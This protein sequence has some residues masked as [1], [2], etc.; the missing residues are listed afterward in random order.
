MFKGRKY[1]YFLVSLQFILIGLLALNSNIRSN[2]LYLL[3]FI[4]GVFVG[5]W[6]I[7]VM[8]KSKLRITPDVADSAILIKAGP[9][10]F[11]RHPMYLSVLTAC[12]SFVLSNINFLTI[13]FFVFLFLDLFLKMNYEEKLLQK[14]FSNYSEYMTKTKRLIPYLY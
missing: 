12:L 9:Y 8:Q 7:L 2:I 14:A 5:G 10:K 11:I 1:S 4:L 13:L 3:I 6:A